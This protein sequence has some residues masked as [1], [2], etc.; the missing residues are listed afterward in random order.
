MSVQPSNIECTTSFPESPL[1]TSS[2]AWC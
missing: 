1:P 2:K